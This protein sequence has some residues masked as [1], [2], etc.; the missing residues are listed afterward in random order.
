MLR[1]MR[2]SILI[3]CGLMCVMSSYSRRYTGYGRGLDWGDFSIGNPFGNIMGTLEGI[4]NFLFIA[5]IVIGVIFT[6]VDK[7]KEFFNPKQKEDNKQ[8]TPTNG[9]SKDENKN[10][11]PPVIGTNGPE[12]INTIQDPISKP[13][14]DINKTCQDNKNEW[15]MVRLTREQRWAMFKLIA[16]IGSYKAIEQSKDKAKEIVNDFAN[17]IKLSEEDRK[18]ALSQVS[19]FH[20]H[21]YIVVI[22]GIE[23]NY[24]IYVLFEAWR[25]LVILDPHEDGTVAGRLKWAC[26]EIGFTYDEYLDIKKGMYVHKYS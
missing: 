15:E 3:L 10:P 4:W 17:T 24:P 21:D 18:E 23:L 26:K 7:I 1:N 8:P 6:L 16:L 20:R 22:K 11:I 25:K 13:P 19:P 5:F 12:Y 14:K 9:T 2:K